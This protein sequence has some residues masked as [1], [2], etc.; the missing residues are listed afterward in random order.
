VRLLLVLPPTQLCGCAVFIPEIGDADAA[1]PVNGV[2]DAYPPRIFLLFRFLP[3][4]KAG[5][6]IGAGGGI[7][8]A[9]VGV[10]GVGVDGVG[11]DGDVADE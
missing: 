10:A 6:G 2:F 8:A 11:V 3:P 9:G 5:E 4:A 7:G 1:K